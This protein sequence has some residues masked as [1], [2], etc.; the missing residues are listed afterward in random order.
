MDKIDLRKAL[1]AKRR[2]ILPEKW[3]EIN[4]SVGDT[5][6][7]W[8]KFLASQTIMVYMAMRDEVSLQCLIEYAWKIGKTVAVP[9]MA[10]EFGHMSAV[11]IH[12]DSVWNAAAFGIRE[13]LVATPVC[14]GDIEIVFLS[15]VAFNSQGQRLGMGGGYYDRFLPHAQQAFIVGV[16]S[17]SQLVDQIPVQSYD[18]SV[19]AIVTESGIVYCNGSSR[20]FPVHEG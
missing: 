8:P 17:D 6:L 12:P 10:A 19:D 11:A 9:K 18:R 3:T 4:K 7:F 13:P 5:L 15:G 20:K 14:P 2:A 16:T 1:L